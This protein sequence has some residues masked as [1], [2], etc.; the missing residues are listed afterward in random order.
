MGDTLR[1]LQGLGSGEA[2]GGDEVVLDGERGCSDA[3]GGGEEAVG[4]EERGRCGG[5][6]RGFVS[7]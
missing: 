6:G 7:G 5:K 1:R 3:F 4:I 2:A